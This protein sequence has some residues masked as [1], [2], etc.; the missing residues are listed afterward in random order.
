MFIGPARLAIGSGLWL[1]LPDLFAEMNSDL[2]AK[3]KPLSRQNGFPIPG[4]PYTRLSADLGGAPKP[5]EEVL[6]ASRR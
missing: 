1:T 2:L 6:P 3:V 5:A 4:A